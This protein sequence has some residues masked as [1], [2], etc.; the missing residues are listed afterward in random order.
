MK[1][2]KQTLT[3]EDPKK[4]KKVNLTATI[5]NKKKTQWN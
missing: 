4:T 2:L 1:G 5:T 3:K